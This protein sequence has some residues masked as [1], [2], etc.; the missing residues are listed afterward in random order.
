MLIGEK[1]LSSP[2][3][4]SKIGKKLS[5]NIQRPHTEENLCTE[6]NM[7]FPNDDDL[8]QHALAHLGLVPFECTECSYKTNKI[9]DLTK[10]MIEKNHMMEKI[11]G[12]DGSRKTRST[13]ADKLKNPRNRRK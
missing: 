7:I 1:P 12:M 4:D 6:C 3:A 10:H 11:Q 2:K 13:F 9:E 8:S 5:K